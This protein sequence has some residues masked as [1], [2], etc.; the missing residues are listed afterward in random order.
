MKKTCLIVFVLSLMTLSSQTKGKITY[1]VTLNIDSLEQP[2]EDPKNTDIQNDVLLMLHESEPIDGHLIFNDSISR[3]SVDPDAESRLN[4]DFLFKHGAVNFLYFMAGGNSTFYNDWSR[5]YSISQNSI[6]GATKRILRE[7][8]EW[9]FT[10]ESKEI[11]GYLCYLATLDKSKSDT[12]LKVWY[13][14]K[15]PVKHGPAGY[16]GLPGL[17]MEIEDKIYTWKVTEIDFD[18]EEADDIIEPTEGDLIT[19]EEFRELA[20]NPFGKN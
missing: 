4:N 1:R 19:A 3:Y 10:N 18:S 17:V 9:T 20:G 14:S 12:K 13:N 11:D 6:L 16:S 2:F 8:L 15:I 7:P 5:N